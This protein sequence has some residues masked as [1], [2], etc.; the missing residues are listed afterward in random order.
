MP[1]INIGISASGLGESI[2]QSVARTA[3]GGDVRKPTVP[4]GFAGT[5]TTRTDNNT[6]TITLAGGHGIVTGD[7]VD[8][9]FADGVQY[10]VTVGT[11]SGNSMPFDLGIGTNL[12]IA[13]TAVVVSKRLRVVLTIDID[14]L[15]VL[16]MFSRRAVTNDSAMS[17]IDFQ[18]ASSE[19]LASIDL[20]EKGPYL[21]D[22]NGADLTPFF[23]TGPVTKAYCSNGSATNDAV[24]QILWLQDSTT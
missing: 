8:I 3:D 7:K 11:V 16:A 22:L 9:Y 21:R 18:N 13:T 1:T 12:P 17:R 2:S 15:S 19:V 5:L 20:E 24:L 4:H 23:G 10:N 14:N 6:G